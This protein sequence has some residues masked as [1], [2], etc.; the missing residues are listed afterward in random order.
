MTKW[1]PFCLFFFAK[2]KITYFAFS[3]AGLVAGFSFIHALLCLHRWQCSTPGVSVFHSQQIS[4][5]YRGDFLFVQGN[6]TQRNANVQIN[7][8]CGTVQTLGQQVLQGC[9]S[10]NMGTNISASVY[11]KVEISSAALKTFHPYPSP[12]VLTEVGRKNSSNY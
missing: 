4:L 2:R 3:Q 5:L 10:G 1:C 12:A 11:G 6:H 7:I 8:S 9:R